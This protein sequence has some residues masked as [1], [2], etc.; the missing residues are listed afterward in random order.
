MAALL[1]E[2]RSVSEIAE[3]A[4]YKAGYV[5]FLLKQ[6]YRKQSLSGQVALVRRVLATYA[7]PRR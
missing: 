7:L 4:G 5:R 3:T 1:A 2:G 6:A